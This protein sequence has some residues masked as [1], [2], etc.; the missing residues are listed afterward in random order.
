MPSQTGRSTV[1]GSIAVD[2]CFD[3]GQWRDFVVIAEIVPDG[4]VVPVRADYAPENGNIDINPL[5][6]DRPLWYAL[7]DLIASK[8]LTGQ[9]PTIRRALRFVPAGG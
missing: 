7:P 5:H 9:T 4:D 6:A 2:D 8:L 3:P 1:L